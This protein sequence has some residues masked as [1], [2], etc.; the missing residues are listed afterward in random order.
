MASSAAHADELDA[1]VARKM[2]ALTQQLELLGIES[3]KS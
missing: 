2:A 1:D 3:P